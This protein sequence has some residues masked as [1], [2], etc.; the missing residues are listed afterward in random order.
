MTYSDENKNGI[1]VV[2][3][4]DA[5]IPASVRH[6]F[7]TVEQRAVLICGADAGHDNDSLAFFDAVY[8]IDVTD[9]DACDDVLFNLQKGDDVIDK[10]IL[11][12]PSQFPDSSL[13]QLDLGSW[14]AAII[15]HLR[16]VF[17]FS[18]AI[19]DNMLLQQV[20]G[21]ILFVVSTEQTETGS[22]LLLQIWHEAVRSFSR[23]IA[24]EYGK[25]AILSN[26]IVANDV[27][28]TPERNSGCIEFF[29]SDNA[30]F[31]TGESLLLGKLC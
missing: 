22:D 24:K 9:E 21:K 16:Y 28:N 27:T 30:T 14:N 17:F 12:S 7:N 8:H 4:A 11:L 5:V 15:D 26:V 29:L 19:I 2:F 1:T 25:F 6:F 18:R 23:S 20:Q 31:I 13:H 3:S 10:C